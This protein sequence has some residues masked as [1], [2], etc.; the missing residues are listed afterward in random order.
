LKDVYGRVLEIKNVTLEIGVNRVTLDFTGYET[1]IYFIFVSADT[2]VKCVKL[3]K[4]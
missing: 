3:V 1:G 2:M 4:G